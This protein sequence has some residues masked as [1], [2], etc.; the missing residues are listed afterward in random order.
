LLDQIMKSTALAGLIALALPAA[1]TAARL[2]ADASGVSASLDP[3]TGVYSLS[4][5]R[6]A[7]RFTGRLSGRAANVKT[8]AGLDKLGAYD[9]ISFRWSDASTPLTGAIRRYRERPVALFLWTLG[10][11]LWKQPSAFPE[12]RKI[13]R[14]LHVF[15]YEDVNFARGR[16]DAQAGGTPWLLFND[17]ADAAIVSP[18]ANFMVSRMSG[19]ARS[20]ITSGLNEELRDLPKGFAHSTIVTFGSG[21]N[22]TWD[23]WGIAMTDLLGRKRPSNDADLFL[24]CLGYWTDNGAAYY[25]NYD[26]KLGYDGTLLA[27]AKL[28]KRRG[29]PIR[30]MQ[31]D[32]WWYHKTTVNYR[33][34][35]ERRPKVE[36]LPRG[37]WNAYGGLTKY[38]AHPFV[39]PDG[40]DGFHRKVGMPLA[41]HNRWVDV[42]SPYRSQYSIPGLGSTDP[43][44]W[45]EIIGYIARSGV[46][47]YEQDWLNYIYEYSPR[48]RSEPYTA[49][50]F[51]DAMAQ[52]CKKYGLSMQYCMPL[53]RYYLQGAK[54]DNLTNVRV[55]DD[56]FNRGQWNRFLYTSRFPASLGMWPWVDVFMSR[57]EDNLLLSVL[58]GGL[59][60]I[61]DAMGDESPA[62]VHRAVRPDGVIVKPDAS[63]VPMDAAYI[64]DAR[65]VNAAMV[66]STYTQHGSRR[67]GYVFAFARNDRQTALAFRPADLG[68]SGP[69]CV[70]DATSKKA[71]MLSAA[72]EFRAAVDPKGYAYYEVAPL[73]VSGI[74]F[75][76]DPGKFVGSGKQRIAAISETPKTLTA[77]VAFAA[78]EGA[79]YVHGYASVA[80]TASGAAGP[81]LWDA[82][83][84]H[85]RV[86]VAPERGSRSASVRLRL[87]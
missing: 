69:V 58:S 77:T 75:L 82:A 5:S 20:R 47:M 85:F 21:I 43:R 12:F 48:F 44:F 71:A 18:A 83:T 56:R 36:S 50:K 80:P 60:G 25:Y 73:G 29:I 52:A 62:N 63:I 3:A 81:V 67:T 37:A 54:Y 6:P 78:G 41:T 66:A 10:G 45:D 13:A 53:P 16:F 84:R 55:S 87:P 4:S 70:Y 1:A 76:G 51:T 72:S 26:K 11:P 38:E 27:E 17:A 32:S 9:Q 57:E 19:D 23:R 59:V 14:G 33:G 7:F 61:G 24:K 35:D 30:Y 86:A 31:L 42:N 28:L 8:A 15:S 68:L 2:P 79:V 39:F 64:N 40:L 46:R 74:A 65:K 49:S 34:E 22:A